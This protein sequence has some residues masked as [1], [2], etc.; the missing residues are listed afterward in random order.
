MHIKHTLIVKYGV[1]F[2]PTVKC[3]ISSCAEPRTTF[4]RTST[5]TSPKSLTLL[6]RRT[7]LRSSQAR[8]RA[9]MLGS[10]LTLRLIAFHTH[11]VQVND[12][13]YIFVLLPSVTVTY[14]FCFWCLFVC[15]CFVIVV[16]LLVTPL[17]LCDFYMVFVFLSTSRCK[18]FSDRKIK[19]ESLT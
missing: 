17:I 11:L 19:I 2:S 10:L 15:Y 14:C 7:I 6:W 9:Y 3:S 1:P 8:L 4:L 18:T 12:S 16:G 5:Q 13:I